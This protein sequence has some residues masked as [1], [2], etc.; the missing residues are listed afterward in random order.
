MGIRARWALDAVKT[1]QWQMSKAKI[2]ISNNIYF[3]VFRLA[4]DMAV[5]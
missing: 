2:L 4:I 5:F 1:I 3:K